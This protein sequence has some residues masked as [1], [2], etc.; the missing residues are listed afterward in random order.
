MMVNTRVKLNQHGFTAI[1][2]MLIILVIAVIGGGGWLVL[3]K[4]QTNKTPT[5]TLTD[6]S[7][8]KT[9]NFVTSAP[10]D[11][12]QIQSVSTFRS[13]SGHDYSG[14]DIN[15]L[16]ETNRSMKNYAVPL[17]EF[18]GTND[19]VKVIAP[20]DA[21]VLN[22]SAGKMGDNLDLIPTQ[23]PGYIYE[24]GHITS[25]KSLVNGSQVKSGQLVGYYTVESSGSAFD[26]QLWFGGS[27]KTVNTTSGEFDS[28]FSHL[29]PDLTKQLAAHGMTADNLIVSKAERDANPC[30]ASGQSMGVN[31]YTSDSTK[32]FVS[33]TR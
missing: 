19:K 16:T 23:A 1:E 33:V 13:C 6:L 8:S 26:L 14:L 25:L 4:Y 7:G 20:F 2:A 15:G 21:T 10:F 17:K 28:L 22:N 31:T 24:L 32:D 18:N 29:S 27:N 5:D 12:N 30:V 11:I 9:I 3:N